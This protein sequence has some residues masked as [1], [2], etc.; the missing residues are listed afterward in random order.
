M[1]SAV[2]GRSHTVR[3]IRRPKGPRKVLS[4]SR[5]LQGLPANRVSDTILAR[6]MAPIKRGGR[7]GLEREFRAGSGG[8]IVIRNRV[9]EASRDRPTGTV[10]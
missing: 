1:P 8:V 10:P 9:C 2:L 6:S 7:V 3:R 5:N 4:H